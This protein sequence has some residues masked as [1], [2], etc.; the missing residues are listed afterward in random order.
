MQKNYVIRINPFPQHCRSRSELVLRPA[1]R[2]YNRC[3]ERRCI[4]IT[5]TNNITLLS[6]DAEACRNFDAVSSTTLTNTNT[7]SWNTSAVL[8]DH[9]SRV[10]STT[11][12]PAI[13][14]MMSMSHTRY[15]LNSCCETFHIA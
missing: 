8:S 1:P 6:T 11:I 10:A 12:L 5:Y 3:D 14:S 7:T 9:K 2:Y 4:T 13:D 15:I